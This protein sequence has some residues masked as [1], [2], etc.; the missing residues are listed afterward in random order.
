[1]K[2]RYLVVHCSASPNN[3]EF[4]AADIHGWHIERGWVGIGYHAVIQRDGTIE[5]GRPIYWQGAHVKGY[6]HESL[7]VCLIGKDTFTSAQY[8]SLYEVLQG[9]RDRFPYADIVGHGDLDSKKS[10]CP[11]FAVRAW[12]HRNHD[13]C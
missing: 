8:H 3:R 11:G 9:W 7:G 13:G 2:I 1:M 5:A 12:W 10:F 6:N 4:T